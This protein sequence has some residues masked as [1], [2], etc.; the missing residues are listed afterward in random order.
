MVMVMVMVVVVVVVVPMSMHMPV[1]VLMR[2]R[3]GVV[4]MRCRH[5]RHVVCCL[6]DG[7]PR[8]T[9]LVMIS[10]SMLGAAVVVMIA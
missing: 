6:N 5:C 3:R 9:T 1:F 10:R 2:A 7:M 8:G 4:M